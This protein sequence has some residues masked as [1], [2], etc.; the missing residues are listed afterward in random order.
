MIR[1]VLFRALPLDLAD[2]FGDMLLI[3][4]TSRGFRVR[5]VIER[6]TNHS[7]HCSDLSLLP[8][9]IMN[10]GALTSQACSDPPA[11]DLH[12]RDIQRL[13][14]GDWQ[15]APLM[16]SRPVL[17]ILEQFLTDLLCDA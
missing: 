7:P 8:G 16:Q 12:A 14:V 2:Q 4:K 17:T 5:V 15:F 6:G 9:L 13:C 3:E 10:T 11:V 1:L